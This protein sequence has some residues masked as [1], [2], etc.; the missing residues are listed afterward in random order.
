MRPTPPGVLPALPVEITAVTVRRGDILQIGGRP[1]LVVDLF[2]I[3]SGGKRLLLDSGEL[4]TLHVRSR[5]QGLRT[6]RAR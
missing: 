1:C 2:H 3:H 5:F 4:L 6:Y